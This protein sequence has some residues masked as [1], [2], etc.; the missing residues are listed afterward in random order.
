MAGF[1]RRAFLQAAAG[2]TAAAA[3]SETGRRSRPNVLLLMSDQHRWDAFGFTGNSVIRTPNFDKLAAGGTRFTECWAQHPVCMPSRASI[4]T[5]R[6]PS[7]HGVRT[8]GVPLPRTETTLAQ[9]FAENGYR[10]GGAG[11]FH[12][13]PHYPYGS[14]LPTMD[15]YPGPYYGF[16]EFHI[17]EDGRSG[18]Q[19]EWIKK[20]YP[21]YHRK[22]DHEIPLRLH[23]TYWAA[24]HTIDFIRRCV[25]RDEPFF[26]FC[27][28]VDPHHAYDPPPPYRDM[29]REED[30]PRPIGRAGEHEGKP[31]YVAGL[32]KRYRRWCDRVLYHR[33]QYYGEV[34]FI[35]DSIGR[36]LD[37]LEEF[38]VRDNTLIVYLP[39]HGDLLGDHNLFFKGQ[40][41]YRECAN[42]TMLFNWPGKV[43]AG[44]VVEG[45]VQEI[46]VFPTIA[47]LVGLPR[48][49]GVQGR[50]QVEA[51][52]TDSASTGYDSILIEHAI[53][54]ETAPGVPVP[55]VPDCYTVRTKEWRMTY[56]LALGTGE[57]YDLESDP[58]EL[59]NRWG[60]A[61]LGAVRRKMKNLLLDRVLAAR[62]PLPVRE[63]RY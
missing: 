19:W 46:D 31:A 42:L 2:G 43:K 36:I 24:S 59:Y 50:S 35:D 28:F 16:Q 38:G 6:Y 40:Q 18:E 34:T 8:N 33:T 11:K 3:R 23:N 14:P 53:H 10:T 27:S 45:F 41:H 49:P 26:A 5:G 62:D 12:F 32:V 9:V 63:N 51:L 15:T 22:P 37:A 21:E 25:R 44:K 4:F 20:N 58:K 48:T 47:E 60:D 1:T 57:L 39:D 56:Y 17:G 29:Y 52:T 13:I 54:G 55:D 7:V 61:K 30:M